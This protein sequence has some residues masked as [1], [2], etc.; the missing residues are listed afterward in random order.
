MI[1]MKDKGSQE[2]VQYVQTVD[3]K[4]KDLLN[5]KHVVDHNKEMFQ[6]KVVKNKF[7][8]ERN[9]ALLEEEKREI[10]ER[11]ENPNFYIPRKIKMQE[12]EDQRRYAYAAFRKFD[13]P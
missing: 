7:V 6:S 13:K 10:I 8:Q 4:R 12:V 1:R 9:K 3:S 11:G 2:E 5:L